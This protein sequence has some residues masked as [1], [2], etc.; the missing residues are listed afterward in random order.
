MYYFMLFVMM[1]KSTNVIHITES[2]C[3]V[4]LDKIPA[5]HVLVDGDIHLQKTC[6]KHGDFSAII[7]RGESEP[8]YKSMAKR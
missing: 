1:N 8:Y 4:C 6:D 5:R 3:P 2:L 7:W